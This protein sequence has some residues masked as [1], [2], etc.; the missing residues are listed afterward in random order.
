MS[1]FN[2]FI[3]YSGLVYFLTSA[4][5]SNSIR[6][7]L[8]KY[9]WRH[10][11]RGT[12][13]TS[14]SSF[15]AVYRLQIDHNRRPKCTPRGLWSE[16]YYSQR[17]KNVIYCSIYIRWHFKHVLRNWVVNLP[18]WYSKL[19]YK[20]DKKN[21]YSWKNTTFDYLNACSLPRDIGNSL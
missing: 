3:V 7:I 12:R 15:E 17:E 13:K 18:I 6:S 1:P 11:K 19:S 10:L 5:W 16:P 2:G 14:E 4:S 21:L 8:S 20:Q 9:C